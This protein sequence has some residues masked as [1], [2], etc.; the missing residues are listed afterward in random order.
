MLRHEQT[1]ELLM[2]LSSMTQWLTHYRHFKSLQ[3]QNHA[4][5]ELKYRMTIVRWYSGPIKER[6]MMMQY[7]T[8]TMNIVIAIPYACL[9]AQTLH[10]QHTKCN[11]FPFTSP[12]TGCFKAHVGKH[13][14]ERYKILVKY[15]QY[16]WQKTQEGLCANVSDYTS[17]NYG[18]AWGCPPMMW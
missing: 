18:I 15:V 3:V 5:H 6:P 9:T 17:A 1:K 14:S 2:E 12:K 13:V 11:Q 8:R 16:M 10:T 4:Q 7:N